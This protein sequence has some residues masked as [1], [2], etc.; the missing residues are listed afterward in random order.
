MISVLGVR[1]HVPHH[2]G[3]QENGNYGKAMQGYLLY[4]SCDH[5]RYDGRQEHEYLSCDKPRIFFL[6]LR[7]SARFY[8]QRWTDHVSNFCGSTPS[9]LDSAKL[10]DTTY[11]KNNS[12]FL[13]FEANV[14]FG[15]SLFHMF[16]S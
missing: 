15:I 5:D 8:L 9:T 12:S 4:Y 16:R 14:V 3:A 13:L 6:S 1:D 7:A 10:S 2:N 11:C